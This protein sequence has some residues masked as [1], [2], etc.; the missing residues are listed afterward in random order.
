[1]I[2]CVCMIVIKIK[3]YL[4]LINSL[5]QIKNIY[6]ATHQFKIS[7]LNIAPYIYYLKKKN[8]LAFHNSIKFEPCNLDCVK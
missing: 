7:S 6:L 5:L 2:S 4:D 1:M 3:R 8:S